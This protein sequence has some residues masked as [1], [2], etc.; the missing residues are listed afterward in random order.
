MQDTLSLD[1]R[2]G[3]ANELLQLEEIGGELDVVLEVV[4]CVHVVCLLVGIVLLN[5]QTDGGAAGTGT[6]QTDN[7]SAA[8]VELDVDTLVLADAAVKVGVAEVVGLDDLAARDGGTDKFVLLGGDEFL[9][10][11]GHLL[12]TLGLTALVVVTGEESATVNL[13][14]VLLDGLDAGGLALLLTDTG[15]DVEPCDNGPETILLADVVG[16]S[17]E[18]LLTTDVHLVGIEQTAEELP[19]S[20]DLVALETLLLGDEVNGTRCRHGTGQTVDTLLLEVGDQLGVVSND[21]ERVT[22]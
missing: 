7:D 14:E 1:I 10:V 8:V 11:S 2:L 19:A 4:L 3:T 20:G 5:V 18:R 13:P 16:T 21:G 12:G 22:G 6:R 9:H 15:N 17:T